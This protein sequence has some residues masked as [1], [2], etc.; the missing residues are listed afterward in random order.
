ML[1]LSLSLEVPCVAMKMNE[2][3]LIGW[4]GSYNEIQRIPKF[5][6]L[7]LWNLR[8]DTLVE[9]WQ[10]LKAVPKSEGDADKSYKAS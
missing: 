4:E 9:R 7:C 8:E 1:Q 2:G 3:S 10:K 5:P 6:S